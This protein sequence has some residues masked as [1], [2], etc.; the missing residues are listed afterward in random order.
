MTDSGCWRT[1]D[2]VYTYSPTSFTKRELRPD[3]RKVNR[4]G[5]TIIL[6][7]TTERL[8]NEYDALRFIAA[9]TTIPVPKV[10]KF[11][12]VWGAYQLEMEL[13]QGKTLDRIQENREEALRNTEYFITTS[14]L[15]QLRG[16]K[17]SAIGSLGGV[18]IPPARITSRDK[19]TYWP[20]KLSPEPQYNFCHNDLAQHNIIINLETLQ[21]EAIID[22]ELSGFYP[23]DFEEPLWRMRWNDKGYHDMGASKIDSLIDFLKEPCA[24][25]VQQCQQP[26][27]AFR[28]RGE[29]AMPSGIRTLGLMF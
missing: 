24:L 7:W 15:P 29:A 3:E 26:G 18:V 12:K 4:F 27:L 10:V 2:R 11:G 5:K 28:P 16:L 22:W 1:A 6:P 23:P 13:V 21:V 8:Q 20:A 14:V 19:R 25:A 17:S 9:N